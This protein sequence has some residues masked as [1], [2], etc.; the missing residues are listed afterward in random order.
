MV[1]TVSTFKA[2]LG[3]ENLVRQPEGLSRNPSLHMHREWPASYWYDLTPLQF[4]HTATWGPGPSSD[5]KISDSQDVGRG[6]PSILD[7]SGTPLWSRPNRAWT[8]KWPRPFGP[9]SCDADS[10]A[11]GERAPPTDACGRPPR[12]ARSPRWPAAPRASRRSEAWPIFPL[13]RPSCDP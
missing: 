11:R 10:G 8:S 5:R 12:P 2:S 9:T 3:S 6:G 4:P 13:T 1:G 7:F